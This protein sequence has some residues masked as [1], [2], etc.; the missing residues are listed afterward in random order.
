MVDF[1]FTIVVQL[2]LFLLFLGVTH[3]IVLIPVLRT[4]DKREE[5]VEQNEEQ[6][7]ENNREAAKLEQ[8]FHEDMASA[9]RQATIRLEKARREAM[10]ERADQV[11][12]RR[13]EGD[14][15]V[16]KVRAEAHEQVEQE[17]SHYDELSADLTEALEE[18]LRSKGLTV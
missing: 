18:W 10:D 4:M 6:A 13:R 12:R 14:S 3:R 5:T 8:K 2:L 16:E 9:R 1:N 15:V 17:R 11:M 7:Q